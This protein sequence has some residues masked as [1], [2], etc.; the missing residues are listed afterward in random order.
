MLFKGTADRMR[1]LWE[2]IPDFDKSSQ[3]TKLTVG[4]VYDRI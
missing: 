4:S 1:G 3:S 2:L